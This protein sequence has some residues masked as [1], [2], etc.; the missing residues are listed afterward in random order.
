M[1]DPV[2]NLTSNCM[3]LLEV[4]LSVLFEI[5]NV[6]D[7]TLFEY[8]ERKKLLQTP[9]EQTRLLREV[10]EVIPDEVEV[11]GAIDEFPDDIEKQDLASPESTLNV[12][13]GWKILKQDAGV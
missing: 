1:P 13:G 12:N 11:E 6:I 2:F 10:P 7:F 3:H 5:L 8:L 9:D 4:L